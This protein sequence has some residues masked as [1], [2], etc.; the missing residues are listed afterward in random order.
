MI[1]SANHASTCELDRDAIAR[2]QRICIIND[3]SGLCLYVRKTTLEHI[4]RV[5][6]LQ[7]L[8]RMAGAL[9]MLL[10]QT[11]HGLLQ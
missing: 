10:Q 6:L 3:T 2:L 7:A 9:L 11:L 4:V 5:E 1:D 8:C